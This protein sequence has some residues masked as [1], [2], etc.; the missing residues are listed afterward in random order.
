MC[1]PGL[2]G[3]AWTVVVVRARR[4][5]VTGWGRHPVVEAVRRRARARSRTTA[6]AA[7]ARAA[8]TVI[9]VICQPGMPPAVIRRTAGAGAGP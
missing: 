9:R 1:P 3:R 6:V 4:V 8:A 5:S 2:S 7:A